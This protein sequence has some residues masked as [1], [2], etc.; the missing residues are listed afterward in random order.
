MLSPDDE[1][2]LAF[3]LDERLQADPE[4]FPFD[5]LPDPSQLAAHSRAAC[6]MLEIAASHHAHDLGWLR[7]TLSES[8]LR[9]RR[10]DL[11]TLLRNVY[12]SKVEMRQRVAFAEFA[13]FGF[14]PEELNLRVSIDR[15]RLGQELRGR[16]RLE[17]RIASGGVAVVYRGVL[18]NEPREVA[19]KI[20][21]SGGSAG[22]D[23]SYSALIRD[24][25]RILAQVAGDGV[26]EFF[27]VEE[28]E[29]GPVLLMQWIETRGGSG[30]PTELELPEQLRL[31][32]RAARILER[33]HRDDL[34][35]GDVKQQNL[36]V[37][38]Q[39]QIWL[40]DFNITR[41]AP[42][43]QNADGPLPG[44][45]A[46][47]SQ[48]ALVGVAADAGISQDI[49]ALGALLYELIAGEPF[50]NANSREEALV[51]SILM[52]GVHA[53][54]LLPGTPEP[55][56]AICLAATTRHV[57][58]RFA[59]AGDL[60]RSLEE[61]LVG[62]LDAERI[63]PQR[64]RLVAWQLGTGLGLCMTRVRSVQEGLAALLELEASDFLPPFVRDRLGY[65]I[66]VVLAAEDV[67]NSI[68][69]LGWELPGPPESEDL[70]TAG[71]RVK[72]L[73]VADAMPLSSTLNEFE[74]WFRQVWRMV[75]RQIAPRYAEQVLFAT[76]SLQSRF[77][78]RS[79]RARATWTELARKAAIPEEIIAAFADAAQDLNDD[80]QWRSVLQ[81][82][83]Y[84]VSKWLRYGS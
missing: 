65:A 70:M 14:S 6:L 19:V 52:G 36:L 21:R 61:Y 60:A 32:A 46:M 9:V 73:K 81:Q 15:A 56:R 35:H 41:A 18:L 84:N 28:T 64:S 27:G 62:R 1:A 83:D 23:E 78:P 34:I 2:E 44:T 71:Y 33:L 37:D 80:E 49:Y 7:R 4:T 57:D 63:P 82:L 66:G 16:W 40:T 67:E 29:F 59:T 39:D 77:A 55:L 69:R 11:Q 45:M 31:V 43:H 53:P 76:V 38:R 68:Q 79:A 5:L 48:E 10:E 24:E 75:E 50:A 13:S 8:P 26:P 54:E 3:R 20:P 51:K 42:P 25:G 17:E 30:I 12:L 72:H 74:L 22:N 58:R 47:M